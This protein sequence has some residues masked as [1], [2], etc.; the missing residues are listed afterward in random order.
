M[1]YSLYIMKSPILYTKLGSL[2]INKDRLLLDVKQFI[3]EYKQ[4]QIEE[5][6]CVFLRDVIINDNIDD[7]TKMFQKLC[8]K[9]LLMTLSNDIIKRINN[10]DTL[11]SVKNVLKK[12][13][14]NV[15]VC[16]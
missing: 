10:Y 8:D 4:K 13:D 15:K 6:T 12:I 1:S 16:F 7:L 9:Y 2:L 11:L 14:E 5:N 3:C